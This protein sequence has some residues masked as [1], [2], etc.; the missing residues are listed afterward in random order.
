MESSSSSVE[1]SLLV[2]FSVPLEINSFITHFWSDGSFIDRFLRVQL[3]DLNVRVG[4]WEENGFNCVLREISSEHPSK[5][6]FPGLPSHA[7]SMKSQYIQ[8]FDEE[9]KI[10]IKEIN[11][12]LGIPYSDYF[13]VVVEWYV[14]EVEGINNVESDVKIMLGFDF[15]KST[16]LRS[17]IEWNTRFVIDC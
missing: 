1:L 17:T 15:H 16:W 4:E 13:S 8:I 14:F 2:E 6:S 12:F 11:R 10:I 5:V 7:Q 9:K 3:E